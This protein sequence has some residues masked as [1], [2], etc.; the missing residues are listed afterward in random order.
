[1]HQESTANLSEV[2]PT[3]T[4]WLLSII[5][6]HPLFFY[7]LIAYAITWSGGFPYI[8]L[9]HHYTPAIWVVVLLTLG[10]TIASFIMTAATEGQAGVGKL[11]R[12]Y[13]R[14]RVGVSWYL[15]VMIGIP[16]LILLV[17]LTF[18]GGVAAV[19]QGLSH[20]PIVYIMIFFLG[21]PFFEEPGW[22]GFALPHLQQLFGPLRGSLLLGVFWGFWH[23]PLFFIPGYNG[24]GSGFVGISTAMLTFL[25]ATSAFSVILAWISNN[26]RGSLLL[27]MLL[28]ASINTTSVFSSPTNN[29]LLYQLIIY[30][31]FVAFALIVIVITR[32]RLTY[33][34]YI[35][36][37]GLD[38]QVPDQPI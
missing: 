16:A 37:I 22:R 18:P 20:Y 15:L 29:S 21:G 23:L 38:P 24:A 10:P 11:L 8:V 31:V 1:M 3:N 26:T 12:R 32:G 36:E 9:L 34:S 19:L 25:I 13:V 30:A 2:Q 6:R 17:C 28:H 4:P 33:D 14:W 27:V 35:H 7:F 5:R